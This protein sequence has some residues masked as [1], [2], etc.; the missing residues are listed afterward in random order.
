MDRE[1]FVNSILGFP[2]RSR[3]EASHVMAMSVPGGRAVLMMAA[4]VVAAGGPPSVVRGA[5]LAA[6]S[7]LAAAAATILAGDAG[8]HVAALA[9]DAFEGREAGSRGGRA[10]GAYIVEAIDH[11]GLEPAGDSGGYY[12]AFGSMR[13]ILALAGGSDPTVADELVMVSTT[14]T[15]SATAT[16]ATAMAPSASCTTAPTTTP[17]ASPD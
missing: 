11:L 5:E 12:Q 2:R 10:A 16:P 13:N 17:P 7:R 15:T 3:K 8:R 9:D 1:R 14:T 6:A 4:L